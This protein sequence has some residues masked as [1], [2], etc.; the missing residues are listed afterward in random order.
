MYN[1]TKNVM[2]KKQC[3]RCNEVK[4]LDGFYKHPT[5]KLGVY[6]HCILCHKEKRDEYYIQNKTHLIKR[7]VEYRK[8]NIDEAKVRVNNYYKKR[9]KIDLEYKLTESL[10]CRINGGLT[11]YLN[12][13]KFNTSL[14]LLGCNIETWINHLESQFKSDMTW[15]NWGEKWQ[16]DHIKPISLFDLSKKEQQLEAFYYKN[17]QPL[18]TIE[19]QKKGNRI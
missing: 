12:Q 7:A 4:T 5:G 17:T 18:Y 16:I 9:R 6:S 3:S 11:R 14:K 15:D 13:G 2:E 8:N 10:R 19:N 1:R